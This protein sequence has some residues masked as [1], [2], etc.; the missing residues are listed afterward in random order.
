MRKLAYSDEFEALWRA[1]PKRAG[2]NSK[3]KAYRAFKTRL[4]QGY[5][6]ADI[7]AGVYRYGAFCEKTARVGSEFVMMAAT[8]FGPDEHFLEPWEPPA[9]MIKET[10]EQRAA[11]LGLTARPGESWADFERRVQQSRDRV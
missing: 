9:T 2:G 6:L 8:F 10:L 4:K 5:T 11:R 1:Y 7:S 3:A